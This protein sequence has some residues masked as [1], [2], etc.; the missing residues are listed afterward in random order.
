MAKIRYTY[1]QE[2]CKYEPIIVT[3]KA[4]GRKAMRFLSVCFLIGLA[5]S[6]YFHFKYPFL[7]ETLQLE[8]NA[9]LKAE[10]QVL[11]RQF[12]RSAEQLTSLE[13][14]DDHNYRIILDLDP[15]SPTQR[16]AG[17]G[18]REKESAGI[19][20]PIIKYVYDKAEKIKNRLDIETQS[21]Q[22]LKEELQKKQKMWAS[23]PAIQ[24]INNK[25]LKQLHT[26]FGMRMHPTLGYIRPHNGLDFTAPMGSPVYATGDAVV[27]YTGFSTYGNVIYLDHGFGFETRYAHLTRYIVEPGQMIKR[28]QIIGYVGNTGVSAGPHLHYEVHYKNVPIN[29]INFFQRDLSNKEYEKLIELGSQSTTSLD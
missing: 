27:M 20:Y 29:P 11:N 6:I 13:K 9:Q 26:I 25:D 17:V 21:M 14:N 18:G 10:W 15:L 4:F 28:G 24:P 19:S 8:E 3:P 12:T 2:T 1:N 16:E 22:Q 23:R 5:G 7:D